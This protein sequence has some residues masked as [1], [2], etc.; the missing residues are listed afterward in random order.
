MEE[1]EYRLETSAQATIVAG[2]T[3]SV[4]NIGPVQQGERWKVQFLSASG[5]ANAK[6]QVMRGN[7][8]DPSRQLDVT[9]KASGDSSNTDIDL[10]A[11]ES[12]SFWWTA[13]TVGAVMSCAI[14]G[15]RFVKGR[16]AY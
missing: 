5:T 14:S 9:T 12:V 16:R 3:G 7:S 15:Q 6:L 13:G 4:I 2:G 10:R 8:F 1:T 11:G